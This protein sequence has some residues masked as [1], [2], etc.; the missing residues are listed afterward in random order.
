MERSSP[1]SPLPADELAAK[2]R[3]KKVR[4]FA[5]DSSS[6]DDAPVPDTSPGDDTHPGHL[7]SSSYSGP[8]QVTRLPSSGSKL[9]RASTFRS[10][11]A[12]VAGPSTYGRKRSDSK[13]QRSSSIRTTRPRDIGFWRPEEDD[14]QNRGFDWG[15]DEDDDDS[16]DGSRPAKIADVVRRTAHTDEGKT[17]I[18][19]TPPPDA[20]GPETD[21]GKERLEWQSMLASVLGGDILKGESSRIGVERP[22][23]ETYRKALGQSLWWQLRARLRNRNEEEERRRV[24]QRRSRVVDVVLEEIEN[25]TVKQDSDVSAL[26]QVAY[27]LQKL[28][29]V[30]S[31]YPHQ[32]AFRTD[33]PLYDSEAFQQRIDALS[34][35]YSVVTQLQA[36][37]AILQKWTGTEDL[38]I[39]RPS[40]TKEKAL[41]G[42]S[43]FHPLDAKARAHANDLAADDSTFV[44]R[45]LKEDSLR[46]TFEKR[47]FLDLLAITQNAKQTVI[48]HSPWLAELNLPDFQ[49][50]LLRIISFPG[51]LIT[52]ALK[53]RLRAAE[54]LT[55]PNDMVVDDM[56]NSFRSS[57]SLCIIIRRQYEEIVAPD[58]DKRWSIPDSFPSEYRQAV[59]QCIK[60]FFKLLHWKLRNGNKAVYF[61]DTDVLEDE[62]EFLYDAAEAIEGVDLVVAE[63]LCSLTHRL[64]ARVIEYFEEQLRI[65]VPL[66]E[67]S[68]VQ[69]EIKA[70]EETERARRKAQG[71]ENEKEEK[72]DRR[73]PM[74]TEEMVAWYAKI[75]DAI[76]MRYRKLQRFARR[77]THRFD[78]SAEYTFEDDDTDL[79]IERLYLSGHFLVYTHTYEEQGTYV[80]A[81]GSLWDR[82]DDVKQLLLRPFALNLGG[83]TH[84]RNLEPNDGLASEGDEDDEDDARYL[85]LVS[86]RQSFAW[87]GVVMTL[88]IPNPIDLR[89]E[90]SRIRLIADGPITRLNYCKLS[91]ARNLDD[92]DVE[93][94][95]PFQ[96]R[97]IVEAQAHLPKVKRELKRIARAAHRLSEWIIESA[98]HVRKALRG[99]TG[100]QDLIENW[101]VFASDHGHRVA[102]H[103]D[104]QAWARFS[105]LLMR[106]AISWVSF[107]CDNCDPTDRK[108]FRWTVNALEYAMTMTRG[109]NILHLTKGEF[110]LLRS[111]VA[112]C[113]TLLISHFDILGARSS[114]EAK[115]EVE[116]LE[117]SRRL[118]HMHE[119]NDED[120]YLLPR[121]PSPLSGNKMQANI[122]RSLRLVREDRLAMINELDTRLASLSGDQH[123]IGRVLDEEVSE[124]RALVFLAASSSN[125]S[126]R[127]QQGGYIGGGANGS[128]YLGF[129][130]DS[131]GIMAVKEI[132][133]QDITNSPALYKQ[134]KDEADVM[135]ML[136]HPNIVDY[137]GIEVHRDR[138]YIFE[139]YCPGGSL[140]N[141]LEHGRIEDEE[142]TSVYAFQMLQ[143]LEYLHS[144]GVEHRDVKPDN[145]LLGTNQVLKYVDFGAAKV[146][147]KGNRTMAK[148]RALNRG[149]QAG[150]GPAVMNSLAGTPMY[151]APE[152]IKGGTGRLGASDIWAM[153]CC[154]LEVVTGRKPWSNL[155]N[156]W[157]IMFHIGIATQHPPL[158]EP[159]QMSPEGIDFIQQC[160]TLDPMKRPTAE[161]LFLHPWLAPLKKLREQALGS[162]PTVSTMPSHLSS[163]SYDSPSDFLSLGQDTP[164]PAVSVDQPY[165]PPV[166]HSSLV[167]PTNADSGVTPSPAPSTPAVTTPGTQVQSWSADGL[168]D[169]GHA[170]ETKGS[171]AA[172]PPP[173][174]IVSPPSAAQTPDGIAAESLAIDDAAA[175]LPE[176]PGLP[177][178][179]TVS[180]PAVTGLPTS[181]RVLPSVN[182]APREE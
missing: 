50:E 5:Q 81:D 120:D 83:T 169:G 102:V 82:P 112:S 71:Q 97:C 176:H 106:L 13:H 59:L 170:Y 85:L 90:D 63:S 60:M 17:L 99:N 43:T 62:W 86:P 52:E 24:E 93:G 30:E 133:V 145:I 130:L 137:Y 4:V 164:S 149:G 76:K 113:M 114:I 67:W 48:A 172:A 27:I 101:Y 124:D 157:A 56:C 168:L 107:I 135:Q 11:P 129:N 73:R 155:D 31:L 126:L 87:M 117:A 182:F 123:L 104:S 55:E 140:A 88:E 138:V 8:A 32:H 54:R 16:L 15:S 51:R 65:P 181:K 153:G 94:Q 64:M 144:R 47:I 9:A 163:L 125:I 28:S 110:A 132:R 111:K 38:D 45:V 68:T 109:N 77:L 74:N 14:N 179:R 103:M 23:N 22:S 26:D 116:R 128:V 33:K 159:G 35:W 177:A 44:D 139:E 146:I 152:V 66:E 20:A 154:V 42:K 80:F 156:E 171:H 21:E 29:V 96:P 92:V 91:F 161:E 122:D 121:T 160:L 150:E 166:H 136:K 118:A 108:T 141:I 162:S 2:A 72:K 3:R 173:V 143:G 127:W 142:V 19:A 12:P 34:A 61:R 84:G 131:G 37:L 75:L 53:T 151:L 39:T 58:P 95:P 148:T 167:Y 134:I 180:A 98:A 100:T 40:T 119:L 175:R 18:L 115:K 79:L 89:L 69:A 78:N 1:L 41:V 158:P 165:Y 147:I 46:R 36:Q 70:K 6:S 49:Y 174:T 10:T 178:E 25:F 105:R 7:R 57:V